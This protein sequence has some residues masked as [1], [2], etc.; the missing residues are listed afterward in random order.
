MTTTA[1]I[2]E[3]II[4]LIVDL[5]TGK[6]P[7]PSVPG[8]LEHVDM[9][10]PTSSSP[11]EAPAGSAQTSA[12]AAAA[13][14]ARVDINA[15]RRASMPYPLPAGQE[16][17]AFATRSSI[18]PVQFMPPPPPPPPTASGEMMPILPPYPEGMPPQL[19]LCHST[20]P[21]KENTKARKR[22]AQDARRNSIP[23]EADNGPP[24]KKQAAP[25]KCSTCFKTFT[26][27][28]SLATHMH[29]HTGEK[30]HVCHQCGRGFSVVSNLR[31]HTKIH[32]NPQSARSRRKAAKYCHYCPGQKSYQLFAV[33]PCPDMRQAFAPSSLPEGS[34]AKTAEQSTQVVPSSRV[35]V[36]PSDAP[37]EASSQ[38]TSALPPL[39]AEAPVAP[40]S[41]PAAIPAAM[42]LA[43]SEEFH[44]AAAMAPLPQA[45]GPGMPSHLLYNYV[46]MNMPVG[47]PL[48]QNPLFI[49][50]FSSPAV[51]YQVPTTWP[52]GE[53]LQAVSES[54]VAGPSNN[55]SPTLPFGPQD[56]GSS[57]RSSPFTPMSGG[58]QTPASAASGSLAPSEYHPV[59]MASVSS[60]GGK[61]QQAGLLQGQ[62]YTM[63]YMPNA[64]AATCG[65]FGNKSA[66]ALLHDM[67]Q[68]ARM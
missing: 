14:V 25:H 66:M 8:P 4:Q 23:G 7:L 11:I 45:P 20:V 44:A 47:M 10:I 65:E 35:F 13:G 50:R 16:Q 52:F 28:S 17:R 30:P 27:P 31:R 43:G 34:G 29:V 55:V 46:D 61:A 62:Q 42:P 5:I 12:T 1:A 39:A 26:R 51:P 40:P 18:F 49:R 38:P 22:P 48:V 24:A 64:T 19:I 9:S 63:V 41:T 54:P 2:N 6:R 37:V 15:D 60:S 67:D 58:F 33:G 68:L 36:H 59:G 21:A 32:T 56:D 53:Q 3:I 57:N